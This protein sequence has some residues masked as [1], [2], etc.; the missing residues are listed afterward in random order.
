MADHEVAAREQRVIK[1][2]Y[3]RVFRWHI[4]INH[5]IPAENALKWLLEAEI[6]KQ[7]EI[8][9]CNAFSQ[10]VRNHEFLVVMSIKVFFDPAM[11]NLAK[12]FSCIDPVFRYGQ[13]FVGN[14]RSKNRMIPVA[15][16][17]AKII[18]RDHGEG[19]RFLTGGTTCAP[20]P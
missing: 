1:L 7:I 18:Q 11:G 9:E 6:R 2:V 14:I 19:I 13:N 17:S 4:E 5:D 15:R 20:D 16:I 12:F 3:D 8:P 10:A